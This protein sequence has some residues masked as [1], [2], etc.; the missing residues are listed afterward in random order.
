MRTGKLFGLISAKACDANLVAMYGGSV[1]GG[2]LLGAAPGFP[3]IRLASSSSWGAE[4]A[5]EQSIDKLSTGR[6]AS[7]AVNF[8]GFTFL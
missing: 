4:G 1:T 2:L 5:A 8:K 7:E 6:V 3:L